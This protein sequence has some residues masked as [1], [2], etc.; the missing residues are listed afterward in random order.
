M[1]EP[2]P[3]TAFAPPIAPP[4]AE[5]L[6]A[7]RS[8]AE[9]ELVALVER[10]C[11]GER[12]AEEQLYRAHAPRVLQL[13]TRLLGSEEEALDV[14]QDTFVTAFED[15]RQ[16]RDPGAF[17]AWTRQ[18]AVRLVHRRFRRRRLLR[19]LGFG[20]HAP[21]ATLERVVDESASPEVR[22]ELR[23][24]DCALARVAAVDRTAWILRH[25][26]GLALEEVAT[27]TDCSLATAKRR[28]ARAEDAVARHV[29]EPSAE[30]LP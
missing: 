14:M 21:D 15:L 18:V 26:E 20:A 1:L 25:V 27:A 6:R 11:R 9:A 22:A 23:G 13:A 30:V 8:V 12:A 24:I 29:G 5:G 2:L 10:A 17:G 28:I 7:P 3:V 16:L 4:A 19:A